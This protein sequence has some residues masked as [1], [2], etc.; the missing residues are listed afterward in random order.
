MTYRRPQ[1]LRFVRFLLTLSSL[2]PLFVLLPL[3]YQEACNV[4]PA[5]P[6]HELCGWSWLGV[7]LWLCVFAFLVL[8]PLLLLRGR[9]AA[10]RRTHDQ[11]RLIIETAADKREHLV[12]YLFAVFLPLYQT[13]ADAGPALIALGL[14]IFFVIWLFNYLNAYHVN[15]YFALQGYR[16]FQITT[17]A[18]AQQGFR[19]DPAILITKRYHIPARTEIVALML[20]DGV[21]LEDQ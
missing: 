20:A 8:L 10:A 19:S 14:S 9:I 2:S 11:D 6:I 15:P 1:N 13:G 16:M 17:P 4:F 5:G 18:H 21:Y 7:V 3:K 12:A